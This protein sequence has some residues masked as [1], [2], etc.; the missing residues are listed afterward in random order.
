MKSKQLIPLTSKSLIEF[1]S[2]NFNTVDDQRGKNKVISIKDA[3]MSAYAIFSLK[4]PSLLKFDEKFRKKNKVNLLSLFGVENIPSD[5]Q[6]REIID[7]VRPK[8]IQ[9]LFPLLL[10]NIQ[11]QK[12]LEAYEYIRINNR[13]FYLMP[14]DGSPPMLG[15]LVPQFLI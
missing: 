6:T 8:N 14:V 2:K 3:L 9:R 7:E 5:T 12:K 10:K 13:P 1:I 11:R 4:I 15:K